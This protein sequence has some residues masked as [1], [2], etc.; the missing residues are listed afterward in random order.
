MLTDNKKKEI[1]EQIEKILSSYRDYEWAGDVTPRVAEKL[2]ALCESIRAEAL[3]EAYL[4]KQR[5]SKEKVC[6]CGNSLKAHKELNI[7]HKKLSQEE[8]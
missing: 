5:G 8:E 3:K 6:I 7:A 4:D 1:E 2:V